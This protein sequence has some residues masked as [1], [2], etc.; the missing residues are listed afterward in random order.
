MLFKEEI[1]QTVSPWQGW[2]ESQPIIKINK[3][4]LKHMLSRIFLSGTVALDIETTGLDP[5]QHEIRLVQM[6]VPASAGVTAPVD[7][8]EVFVADAGEI[9]ILDQI[10]QIIE[11][12]YIVKI[13]HNAKFD[14]S[15]LQAA[16]GRKLKIENIFDT[17]LASQLVTAGDFIPESQFD[18]Y[19]Q[20]NNLTKIKQGRIKYFDPHG[21]ELKYIKETQK[22]ARPVYPL[23]SLQQVAHRYLEVW[24][25]KEMQVSDWKGKLTDTQIKYA[26]QDAAV[27]LPLH[28]VLSGLIQK[29]NLERV[30][31][32]EFECIPAVIEIEMTGMPFDRFR[33]EEIYEEIACKEKELYDDLQQYVENPNSS[34]QVQEVIKDLAGDYFIDGQITISGEDFPMSSGDNVLSRISAR[35]PDGH[36]LKKFILL[37]QEYRSTKKKGDFLHK[38]MEK[39]HPATGRLHPDL[40]QLNPQGVGRFSARE[41]NLQQ[42]GRDPEI[43]ALFKAP[44]GKKLIISDYSGIEMRIMAQLSRDRTLIEAFRSGTDI[45]RFTASKLSG[46]SLDEVSKTERQASKAVNFGLIYGMSASTLQLYA[47]TGYG[48]KMSSSEAQSS[49][50]M[51]FKTYPGIGKWHK[52]QQWKAFEK[53]FRKYWTYRFDKGYVEQRRPAVRTLSGRLRIW[54]TE[55]S[56]SGNLKKAGPVTEMFNTPDQGTGADMIKKALALLYRALVSEQDTRIIGCV[57]DEII[58]E[59]PEDRAEEV[60]K[61]LESAMLQAGKEFLPDV[62][63]EL[64]T[65]IA[66]S[67]AEKN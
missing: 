63:V 43:R 53:S 52:N 55:E 48:V 40:R 67:W 19:L 13:F 5:F 46:K 3:N 26:A 12:P 25:D 17:M 4:N 18:N 23:H 56:K 49:R 10:L 16:A 8:C 44:P 54:P 42:V 57:H 66:D 64:E 51:F 62:P 24:L 11:S 36:D 37:L 6:A 41:P 28:N 22:Q 32:I 38:W 7:T 61:L 50:E 60:K 21:H 27:L 29:N 14:L 59:V 33:A 34:L 1:I 47:E 58:L 39:L 30:A 2:L 31:K 65:E 45:H 35:L 15:F 9:N 20:K